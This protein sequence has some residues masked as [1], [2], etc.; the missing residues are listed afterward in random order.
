MHAIIDL[1][2]AHTFP[3]VVR[4]FNQAFIAPL[5][6]EWH[7]SWDALNDYL[8]WP[9]AEHYTLEFRGWHTCRGLTT[10]DRVM[11]ASILAD[12]PDIRALFPLSGPDA[13]EQ[14]TCLQRWAADMQPRRWRLVEYS[15]AECLGASD[16]P[17]H[18]V[19]G[20]I[21][22]LTDQGFHLAGARQGQT[23]VLC[24][25]EGTPVPPWPSVFAERDL[26][27]GLDVSHL[28]TDG[29][30]DAERLV[31]GWQT[32]KAAQLLSLLKQ[33]NHS[34]ASAQWRALGLSGQQAGQVLVL[35][36]QVCTDLLYTLLLSLDG[37]AAAGGEQHAF[38]VRNEQGQNLSPCGEL[39]AAAY[40]LLMERRP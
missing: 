35:L 1:T 24:A 19:D 14:A 34:Q 40:A 26:I 15:G 36:D 11:L 18:A 12:H 3:A 25:H 22:A 16:L 5:G 7:G 33:G 21:R 28:D 38:E 20:R 8:S 27:G 29:P 13:A 9:E 6:G 2:D 4:T 31:N 17:A 37:A 23:A 10:D 30:M 39:E 32:E